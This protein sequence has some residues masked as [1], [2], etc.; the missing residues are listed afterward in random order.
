MAKAA[1]DAGLF[2]GTDDKQKKV[3]A[4]VAQAIDLF[5]TLHKSKFGWPPQRRH[6]PRFGK[7]VQ[8]LIA[9]WG[10][11]EVLGLIRYFFET[12]DPRVADRSDY[13]PMDFIN[14][15]QHLRMRRAGARRGDRRTSENLDAAYRATQRRASR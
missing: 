15:S 5:H 13:T 7:E 4:P 1:S 10:L 6:Y 12:T 11:D 8:S 3:P 14:L 9:D 2:P